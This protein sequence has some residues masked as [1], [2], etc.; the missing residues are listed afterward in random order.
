LQSTQRKLLD[1][2]NALGL[3]SSVL[4]LIDRRQRTV[5]TLQLGNVVL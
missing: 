3:G 2:S 4:K 1:V 5:W